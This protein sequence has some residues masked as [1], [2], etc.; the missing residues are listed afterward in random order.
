MNNCTVNG[1]ALGLPFWKNATDVVALARAGRGIVVM[2]TGTGKTTQTPQALYEA[3]FTNEGRIY[4]SVPKRVLAVELAT[5]VADEMGV[6]LGSLV[7][8]EIRGEREVSRDTKILFMTEGMLRAKIRSNPKLEG[9]SVILFDEFH[10][11]SLMSDFNIALVERAQDEG[12]RVAFLLMSATV[13]ATVLATHFNCGM[14]DGTGLTTVYPITETYREASWGNGLFDQTAEAVQDMLIKHGR[15]ANG[16]VFMP[17]KAEIAQAM[18]AIRKLKI[19]GL[20]VLPLHGDLDREDRHAPFAER[21]GATVT[22]ATDIVETGATLPNI[23][24]VV[25]SG[26]AREVSYD[27]VSDT[28][29]LRMVKVAQDRLTQRRGRAGRVRAGEY[30][31]LYSQEDKVNRAQKTQPE[32]LRKPLREVVLTIKALGLSRVGKSLRLIDYPAKANWKEAKRQLQMLKLVDET[33]EANITNL[34][35]KAVELGC[36]PRDAAML[37]AS[38]EFGCVQ[39]AAT[40][41]AARDSRLLIRPKNQDEQ[42]KAQSAHGKF[43]TSRTCDA[44]TSVQVMRAAEAR[45]EQSVGAWCKENYVSYRALQ[46]VWMAERQLVSSMRS[47][48]CSVSNGGTEEQLRKAIC[49]GLPDRIFTYCRRPNWHEQEG[50]D[51]TAALGRESVIQPSASHKLVAW[52]IIEIQTARGMMKLITNATVITN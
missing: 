36:D 11:R 51:V 40:A 33:E 27:P 5:R 19:E 44:W 28:S 6:G 3:G 38:V 25:D 22:I 18:D 17:G 8:Y 15:K 14:V 30:V 2:P 43:R 46:E 9:V 29:A 20:T 13:D 49:A 1:K 23:G 50:G 48:G 21:E 41:I 34:G 45:G 42:W 24:W 12:S 47:L 10:Q 31:G 26:L 35:R 4:V 32:I 16:L 39:E 7:G 37:L 52:E